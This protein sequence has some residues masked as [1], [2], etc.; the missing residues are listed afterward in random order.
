M[1]AL[2]DLS[3]TLRA[4][5]DA[6]DAP[7]FSVDRS[8]RYT[9][10]NARHADAMKEL[11]GAPI[12][13]GYSILDYQTVRADRR[14]SRANLDRALRGEQVTD[15]EFS[16]G[17]GGSRRRRFTVRYDPIRDDGSV[18]GVAVHARDVTERTV[19][20][21][22]L[23]ENAAHL[24]LA[25]EVGLGVFDADLA[26]GVHHWDARTREIWGLGPDE[27]VSD[28]TFLA[29]VHPD[30]REQLRAA[31][32]GRF[33]SQAEPTFTDE[34]RVINRRDDAERWV[35]VSGTTLFEEGRA[36][37]TIGFV[38]E[39]SKR[40]A[41]EEANARL[42]AIVASSE[43][44]IFSKTLEGTILTW[45]AGAERLYG[46]ASD[47][48]VGKSVALLAPP[49]TDDE[50]ASLLERISHGDTVQHFET[51]RVR[52]NGSPVEV[53]LSISP[54]KDAAGVIVGAATIA[55]DVSRRRQAEERLRAA[56]RY[57]RSLIEASLD[58]LVTISPE[59][60]VTD[61][62]E[63]TVEATG[64]AREA[65]VGT[66]FS[67]YFTEP[68]RAR[69]GYLRVLR[70]G[71][72]RNYPLGLRHRSGSV[73][74]IEYN[75]SVLRD[76]RGELQ[77]VFAAARDVSARRQA[78][79]A[80]RESEARYRGYVDS[81][82]YGVLVCDEQGRYVEVN[83]AAAEL[84]GYAQEELVQLSIAD[85]LAP[86]SRN[87]GRRHFA[88]VVGTGH[89]SGDGVFLRKDGTTFPAR[90][91]AVRLTAT[92]YLGFIADISEQ[93]RAAAE[94]EAN[95][96]QLKQAL[97]ATVATLGVATE[98]R[99]PYTA[100]H[101]QRVAQLAGAIAAGLG[102]DEAR[103]EMVET[104][105]L[106][107]DVGKIVVPAE[108]LAKPGRLNE[109]EMQVIRQHASASAALITGIEFGGPVA[110]IVNQHHE[111]LDGSGYPQGLKG[112]DI[113]P[114]ARILAVADVVEAMVSHRPYRA[115]LPLE[116][117]MAEIEAGAGIRY[118][119]GVC[120]AAIRL[121][122][123]QGFAFTEERQ[124]V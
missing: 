2:G 64:V 67:D 120:E 35:S 87:W 84:T 3:L 62:N 8:Y 9:S 118:D 33:V 1:T 123:E 92:R 46:Y 20:E 45:N 117:A 111:R 25:L 10:F 78:E 109:V 17:D 70:D 24:R 55:R 16:G 12:A 31:M 60:M 51:V 26:S 65:I 114:E 37:R 98:L 110:A 93:Q 61:V 76:E 99:D 40:K 14:A 63:A 80:L 52:K 29:G 104:A 81:A 43:D 18:I 96:A 44:A 82:P 21:A 77:G 89:A 7:V 119:A 53:S 116:E 73:T 69:D 49:G 85:I 47:E 102:Y 94:V 79:E 115:A 71:E 38:V 5:I 34:Y 50:L 100:G 54:I 122:R 124:G 95:A 86:Q 56:S 39:I 105:G 103:I 58:P 27:P 48:I 75:A 30:D 107:H 112:A 88:R 121:F 59:G 90:V 28:E 32:E 101:Q 113:L 13:L 22:A 23:S 11:Y 41:A 42:A 74:D 83:K 91:D 4:I 15:E 106:L 72:V 19:I 68:E 97:A 36:V 108:I 66:D 57:A 6:A